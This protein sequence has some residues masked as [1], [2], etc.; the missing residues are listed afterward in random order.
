MRKI[1]NFLLKKKG[2]NHFIGREKLTLSQLVIELLAFTYVDYNARCHDTS[3]LFPTNQPSKRS[4]DKHM[5]LT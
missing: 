1:C 5:F 4:K 3:P 2:A